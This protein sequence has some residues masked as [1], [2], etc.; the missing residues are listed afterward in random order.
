MKFKTSTKVIVFIVLISGFLLTQKV[1]IENFVFQKTG[2]LSGT[3]NKIP[4]GVENSIPSGIVSTTPMIASP[5]A[6]VSSFNLSDYSYPGSRVVSSSQ[7]VVRLSS[8]DDPVIIAKWYRDRVKSRD[9]KVRSFIM[10]RSGGDFFAEM[11][12]SRSGL[13]IGVD[14]TRGLN[15]SVSLIQITYLEN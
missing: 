3:L 5:S 6:K 12:G 2:I 9:I 8:A 15:D 14:V 7:G 1:K 11:A 10:T 4:A 13:E